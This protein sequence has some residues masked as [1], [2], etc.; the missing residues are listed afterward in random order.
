MQYILV[1][2]GLLITVIGMGIVNVLISLGIV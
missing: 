1:T 2:S